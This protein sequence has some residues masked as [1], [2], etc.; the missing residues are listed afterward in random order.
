MAKPEDITVDD[1]ANQWDRIVTANDST[2]I[3]NIGQGPFELR[4]QRASVNDPM[5]ATQR[6]Y[7]SREHPSHIVLPIVR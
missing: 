1:K 5:S 6:I 4:L 7:T 2:E 3:A